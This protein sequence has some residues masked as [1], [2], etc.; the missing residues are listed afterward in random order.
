MPPPTHNTLTRTHI[1]LGGGW[2]DIP[3]MAWLRHGHLFVAWDAA[4][5]VE[6][7]YLRWLLPWCIDPA[8]RP[9]PV[10]RR[11]EGGEYHGRI[12]TLFV[13]DGGSGVIRVMT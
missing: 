1:A 5:S 4:K 2:R 10:W 13:E 7:Y 9:A 6:S 8:P 3:R 11:V 12:N